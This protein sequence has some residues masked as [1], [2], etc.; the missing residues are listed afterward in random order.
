MTVSSKIESARTVVFQGEP[1]SY[2]HLACTEALPHCEAITAPTF[3]DAFAAIRNH[4]ADLGLIPIENS[5]TGMYIAQAGAFQ[6]VNSRMSEIFGFA[7]A[8]DLIQREIEL[9]EKGG[10]RLPI[11]PAKFSIRSCT[12][13]ALVGQNR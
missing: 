7:Q 6:F 5:L 10:Q 12:S 3:E 13:S 8:E 4:K 9:L 11:V 1:G 2:S